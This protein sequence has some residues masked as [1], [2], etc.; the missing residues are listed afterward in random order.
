MAELAQLTGV[1]GVYRSRLVERTKQISN[2]WEATAHQ[3]V[4]LSSLVEDTG[5]K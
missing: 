2:R 4:D 1:L 5:K 3:V